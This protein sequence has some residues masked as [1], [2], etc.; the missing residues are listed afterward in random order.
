MSFKN[1]YYDKKKSEIH[2]W[3]K[4]GYRRYEWVPY[5]FIPTDKETPIKSID[6][7]NV[8]R[9][10]FGNYFEYNRFQKEN[11]DIYENRVIP[12]IQFLTEKYHHIPDE[13]LE[14]PE[15]KIF[16]LDIEVH[17]EGQFPSP[18]NAESPIVLITVYDCNNK[19][20]HTF[21]LYEFTYSTLNE[22]I[23][24]YHYSNEEELLS[25]FIEFIHKEKPDVITGWNIIPSKKFNISGFDIPYIIYRSIKLFGEE[26][27]KYKKLSPINIV[28]Y[29]NNS[30]GGI[31]VDIAGISLI[32][33]EANY[34]WDT[35]KNP[36]SYSLDYI[37]RMELGEGKLDYI[38]NYGNLRNLYHSDWNLFVD[39]N[40]TDSKRVSEL[41]DKQGYIKLIQT[42]SLITKCPMKFYQNMTTLLESRLLTYFRRNNLC[43]PCFKGGTQE[44]YTAAYVKE[45]Q[46]GFHNW[47]LALDISS[48]YPTTIIILNLSIETYFGIIIDL[49]ENSIMKYISNRKFPPFTMR[50]FNT[51]SEKR[52]EGNRLEKFNKVLEKGLISIAPSGTCFRTTPEGI[53]P[54]IERKMYYLRQE[55]KKEIKKE[56]DKDRKN[57]L[58]RFQNS[59][60][61]LLN[62]LYGITAVPYSRF[63]NVDLAKAITYCSRNTMKMGEKFANERLN[64]KN[65]ALTEIVEELK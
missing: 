53:F 49:D 23:Y 4:L 9:K 56:T 20:A 15:L 21:G 7:K 48:S 17:T 13:E 50:N 51:K 32:D 24:Y 12:E 2:L 5:I 42:L 1:I 58:D 52:F 6:G 11:E 37:S 62:S 63:F 60:K 18:H 41:E 57:Q 25:S 31:N 45:P 39:Y 30:N 8:I 26:N 64:Y 33:Y 19:E 43:A 14:A 61:L 55:K 65:D 10:R 36:E 3:D 35:R 40:I 28:N 27:E 29:W 47:I 54:H 16:S 34:K 22:T 44:T 46:K 38:K 59:L